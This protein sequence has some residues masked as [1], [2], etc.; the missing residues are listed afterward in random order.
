MTSP[1]AASERRRIVS[2]N[3]THLPLW[4]R[5]HTSD[6]L[7]SADVSSP[8]DHVAR[9]HRGRDTIVERVVRND[10]CSSPMTERYSRRHYSVD[11][12]RAIQLVQ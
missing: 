12:R 5:G 4:R 7:D 1:C 11:D 3:W 6:R 8:G 10:R 2:V 9:A